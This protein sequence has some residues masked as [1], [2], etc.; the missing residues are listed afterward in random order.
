MWTLGA[1]AICFDDHGHPVSQPKE[2]PFP[3]E[4]K[5]TVS[6]SVPSSVSSLS[7]ALRVARR[8]VRPTVWCS[9]VLVGLDRGAQAPTSRVRVVASQTW[10]RPWR[11][12]RTSAA[13]GWPNCGGRRQRDP[14]CDPARTAGSPC[15]QPPPP[16]DGGLGQRPEGRFDRRWHA[17]LKEPVPDCP[18]SGSV[19][20]QG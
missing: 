11:S 16:S 17:P 4:A 2:G 8:Q 19:R 15:Q 13:P 14:G 6:R 9:L 1:G 5:T 3:M 12:C 7:T 10:V 18:V 20:R